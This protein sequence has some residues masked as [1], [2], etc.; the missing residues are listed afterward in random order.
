M[1]CADAWRW[2]PPLVRSQ[3]WSSSRCQAQAQFGNWT[4]LALAALG[5]ELQ[6][7]DHWR[8]LQTWAPARRTSPR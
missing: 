4:P 5:R 2:Q 1:T 8:E 3:A 7:S 6:T